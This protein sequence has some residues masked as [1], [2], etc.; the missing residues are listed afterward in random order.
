MLALRNRRLVVRD[1]FSFSFSVSL[2]LSLSLS[3]SRSLSLSLSASRKEASGE[4][5]KM[6]QFAGGCSGGGDGGGGSMRFHLSR[7]DLSASPRSP[8]GLSHLVHAASAALDRRRIDSIAGETRLACDDPSRPIYRAERADSCASRVARERFRRHEGS[9]FLGNAWI[10]HERKIT[11]SFRD[12]W[13]LEHHSE[14]HSIS[15]MILAR[16]IVPFLQCQFHGSR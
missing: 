15:E 13:R 10:M 7:R 1:F 6:V 9:V 2:S 3:R 4:F 12:F 16:R 8:R 5:L 11:Q 14:R